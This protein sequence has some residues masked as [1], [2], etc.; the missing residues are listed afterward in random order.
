[1]S[2]FPV[3]KIIQTRLDGSCDSYSLIFFR[4][5]ARFRV[6]KLLRS[7]FLAIALFINDRIGK[8]LFLPTAELP[9]IALGP[10]MKGKGMAKLLV[11]S[12]EYALRE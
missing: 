9:S 6:L 4:E 12:V 5:G 11:F 8:S 7:F 10:D 1:M 2:V 3:I